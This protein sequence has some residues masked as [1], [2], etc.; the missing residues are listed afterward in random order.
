MTPGVVVGFE[1]SG[2]DFARGVGRGLLWESL[3]VQEPH[4]GVG[5]GE[6]GGYQRGERR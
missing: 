4:I 6:K 1:G 2:M 5:V 3:G